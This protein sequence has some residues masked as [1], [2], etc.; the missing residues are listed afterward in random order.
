[1]N[2]VRTVAE[3]RQALA[4]ARREGKTIG[5][6]PT[7]GAFH[8]GHLSLMRRARDLCDV[9]VVSLFVNPTQFNDPRDLERYPRDERRD[10]AMVSNEGVD[11]LFA[12][13]A[14]EM[15]AGGASTIVE[16][17]GISEP[18]EGASRGPAHFRGVSTVVTKLFNIVQPDVAIFGQKDAQQVLVIKRMVRDLDV[19]VRIEVCPTIR[20]SDGLAMSSRNALLSA[21]DRQQALALH[22]ALTAAE[23]AVERGER[24]AAKVLGMAHAAMST[25]GVDPEYLEMVSTDTL[26]PVTRL[27]GEALLAVAARVGGVRLIDNVLLETSSSG[28][29]RE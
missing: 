5:F 16:V 10:A 18:L 27:D 19:P 28:T 9:S 23:Q 2:V 17:R 22:R 3:V 25:F 20:E 24:D 8:A 6:V 21:E 14:D 15:Y 29:P 12:P 26:R 4:P 1:M 13:S 11:W 7:M